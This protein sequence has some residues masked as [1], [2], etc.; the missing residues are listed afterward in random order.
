MAGMFLLLAF[1]RQG[2][3][4]QELLRTCDGCMCAQTRPRF[5]LS[6]E[7]SFGARESEPKLTSRRKIP[8]TGKKIS[9]K[10]D[11]TDDAGPS[12]TSWTKQ[13]KLDQA[14]RRTLLLCR[15]LGMMGIT[16]ITIFLCRPLGVMGITSITIFLCRP[17]GVIGLTPT[18]AF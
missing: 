11:R 8:S 17:L 14:G 5:I 13:N 9:T 3:E 10:E 15:S 18:T 6:S 4:R 1:A 2:H 7:T 16:S 12:R